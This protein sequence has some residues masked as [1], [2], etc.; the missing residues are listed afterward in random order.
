VFHTSQV[1]LLANG[2]TASID[3]SLG[4][5]QHIAVLAIK[6]VDIPSLMELLSISSCI[7]ILGAASSKTSFAVT[8]LRLTDGWTKKLVW[9]IIISMNVIMLANAILSVASC[10][11]PQKI[12]NPTIT[13]TC[14]NPLTYSV[15]AGAYSGA[16]DI[17]LSL[18]PWK[19]TWSLQMRRK[20]KLGVAFA[21]SLGVLYVFPPSTRL[22]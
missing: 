20:E 21:M 7:G 5:G 17:F 19:I 3:V 18:L 8:L 22:S 1:L 13:G 15:F 14:W 11:P 16:M 9:A 12:W 2:I 6:G 4:L 10:N